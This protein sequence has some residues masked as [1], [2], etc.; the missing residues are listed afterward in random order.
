MRPPSLDAQQHFLET[1]AG[2][3]SVWTPGPVFR[4]SLRPL[5]RTQLFSLG[6]GHMR[7][8]PKMLFG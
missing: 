4:G 6:A 3:R 2:G 1:G 5:L 8:G 7:A